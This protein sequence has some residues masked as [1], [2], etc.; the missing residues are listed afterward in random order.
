MSAPLD[1]STKPAR[2]PPFI[3]ALIA[4][5]VLLQLVATSRILCPPRSLPWLASLRIAGPPRLWPF[6]DYPMFSAPHH[7][8]E[9]LAWVDAR[10][11]STD[12]TVVSSTSHEVTRATADETWNCAYERA[13]SSLRPVLE[14]GLAERDQRLVF[15]CHLLVLTDKGLVPP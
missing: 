4:V 14:P 12:G 2:F 1:P 9:P 11:E 13:E 3:A 15:E 10:R 6:V 8:G 7:R 5:S